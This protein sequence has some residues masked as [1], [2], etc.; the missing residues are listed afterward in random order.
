MKKIWQD[1]IAPILEKSEYKINL[2]SIVD[3]VCDRFI[4]NIDWIAGDDAEVIP[5]LKKAAQEIKKSYK[6]VDYTSIDPLH[7]NS[8]KSNIAR[9]NVIYYESVAKGWQIDEVKQAATVVRENILRAIREE[10]YKAWDEVLNTMWEDWVKMRQLFKDYWDLDQI[11]KNALKWKK[12]T[13][14][15]WA[16]NW[17]E[18]QVK[19]R[20]GKFLAE[21]W[22]KKATEEMVKEWAKTLEKWASKWIKW[23]VKGGKW[24]LKWL[25]DPVALIMPD[26]RE[27]MDLTEYKRIEDIVNYTQWEWDWSTKKLFELSEKNWEDVTE[28]IG[29]AINKIKTDEKLRNIIEG[30][31]TDVD[32]WIKKLE[33]FIY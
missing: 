4:N 10:I 24:L 14:I 23:L 7:A 1:S 19:T 32:E 21:Q 8:I 26:M 9:R 28:T 12:P 3:D 27:V 31:W 33:E 17:I 29:K 2:N 13:W 22:W 5:A 18:Q 16:K 30:Q 20:A 6:N 11:A 15:P 25:L